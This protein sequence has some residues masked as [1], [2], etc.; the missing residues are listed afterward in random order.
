MT[1]RGAAKSEKKREKLLKGEAEE[2]VEVRAEESSCSTRGASR[3]NG[4]FSTPWWYSVLL[5]AATGAAATVRGRVS[6]S[7]PSGSPHAYFYF[8]A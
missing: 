1:E 4:W 7:S 3:A 5:G 2:T 6:S 8:L